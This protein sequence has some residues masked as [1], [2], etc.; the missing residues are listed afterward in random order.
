MNLR[1]RVVSVFLNLTL[2]FCALIITFGALSTGGA[3]AQHGGGTYSAEGNTVSIDGIDAGSVTIETDAYSWSVNNLDDPNFSQTTVTGPEGSVAVVTE[4]TDGSISISFETP[5]GGGATTIDGGTFIDINNDGT[6]DGVDYNGDG[7]AD[8]PGE[9]GGPPEPPIEPSPS[10]CAPNCP[11][12]LTAFEGV[13]TCE[14]GTTNAENIFNWATVPGITDYELLRNGIQIYI[15]PDSGPSFF[16]SDKT[17][18]IVNTGQVYTYTLKTYINGTLSTTKNLTF[19]SL[20]CAPA[21]DFNISN[22]APSCNRISPSM[23]ITISRSA[24]ATRY[25]LYRHIIDSTPDLGWVRINSNIP[26][27]ASLTY[28]YFDDS[29]NEPGTT[30]PPLPV[31]ELEYYAEAYNDFSPGQP[32]TLSNSGNATTRTF[33][34]DCNIPILSLMINGSQ[35]PTTV[36]TGN[37]ANLTWSVSHADT[38]TGTSKITYNPTNPTEDPDP[39]WNNRIVDPASTG[40]VQTMLFNNPPNTNAEYT[41]TCTNDDIGDIIT[42]SVAVPNGLAGYWAM[43]ENSWAGPGAVT[44]SSGNASNGTAINGPITV[45]NGQF[46]KAGKFDGTDDY[47][48]LGALSGLNIPANGAFTIIGFLKTSE[49][50]GCFLSFRNSSN[51][52]SLLNLCVGYNGLSRTAGALVSVIRDDVSNSGPNF[53]AFEVRGGSVNTGTWRQFALTRTD[54]GAI[55][56]FIDGVSQGIAQATAG[57]IT[58]DWRALGAEL[59]WINNSWNGSTTGDRY[60]N[61]QLDDIRFYNRVLSAQ[62][63]TDLRTSPTI[64]NSTPHP[65]KT[66]FTTR[67]FTI[68]SAGLLKPFIQ[69]TG[70]DVHTN[71]SI[72]IP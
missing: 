64:S 20:P 30:I 10:G 9:P 25:S 43:D 34:K 59:F 24:N 68:N 4:H 67:T 18:A 53:G 26:Q 33:I 44:D 51:G 60:L 2:V 12:P 72:S 42:T 62:E 15:G 36:N 69:T 54:T 6:Y 23:K 13:A 16:V 41:L 56:L 49:N 29:Y 45:S 31:S 39:N 48:D 28:D 55:E 17:P 7:D 71:E 50:Y 22:P 66:K 11:S 1:K 40:L 19:S 61:G 27:F 65:D 5:S 38:C 58:T 14:I 35:L 37:P 32:P 57:E 47:A 70:G 46:G 21:A 8:D 63:M 3:R 52:N